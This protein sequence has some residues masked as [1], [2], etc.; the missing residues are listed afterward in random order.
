MPVSRSP[1]DNP[2]EEANDD[3]PSGSRPSSFSQSGITTR[4]RAMADKGEAEK[5]AN[6]QQSSAESR[7]GRQDTGADNNNLA[8]LITQALGDATRRQTE[9]LSEF[10]IRQTQLLNSIEIGFQRIKHWCKLKQ[11]QPF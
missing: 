7:I 3:L 4:G 9:A 5:N 2:K 10:S 8:L 6:R 11:Y 1:G